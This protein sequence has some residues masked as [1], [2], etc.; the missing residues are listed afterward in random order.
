MTN[1]H[2]YTMYSY[3]IFT[4][5][6]GEHTHYCSLD[7]VTIAM[8]DKNVKRDTPTVLPISLSDFKLFI[9]ALEET[10]TDGLY[11]ELPGYEDWRSAVKAEEEGNFSQAK[12]YFERACDKKHPIALNHYAYW[13]VDHPDFQHD[14]CIKD[15]KR[16][17]H[18]LQ[19]AAEHNVGMAMYNLAVLYSKG[20]ENFIQPDFSMAYRLTKQ[21]LNDHRVRNDPEVHFFFGMMLV[22]GDGCT[23]N[24]SRG[25]KHIEKAK[26][27]GCTRIPDQ[28]IKMLRFYK[29]VDSKEICKENTARW[30]RLLEHYINQPEDRPETIKNWIAFFKKFGFDV[31]REFSLEELEAKI[32]LKDFLNEVIALTPIDKY[33]MED[34]PVP[35]PK[36]GHCGILN[37]KKRCGSCQAPYCNRTCQE[38][39]WITHKTVCKEYKYSR[40]RLEGREILD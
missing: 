19:Q 14:G 37:P 12:R 32:K 26:E 16:A 18:M 5:K 24:L 13:F 10:I 21:A 28:I 1:Y 7:H 30:R 23:R 20:I 17:F 8:A 39:D 31:S 36:C 3:I 40:I 33:E 6:I 11:P 15:E 27:L 2:P 22:K 38:K 34:T 9:K 4:F 35:P 29:Q 25:H